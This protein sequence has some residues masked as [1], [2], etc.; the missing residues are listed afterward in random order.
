[1]RVWSQ[2]YGN[3][4]EIK[5]GNQSTC[6]HISF[7]LWFSEQLQKK[8]HQLE[9]QLDYEMQAKDELEQKCKYDK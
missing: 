4:R 5:H 9:E 2:Y 3:R 8:L 7:L 1:M 6:S